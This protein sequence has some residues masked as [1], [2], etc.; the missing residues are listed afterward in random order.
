VDACT[1]Q[2]A[3]HGRLAAAP[4]GGFAGSSPALLDLELWASVLS[5]EQTYT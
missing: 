4:D 2:A 5:T 1:R 3:A